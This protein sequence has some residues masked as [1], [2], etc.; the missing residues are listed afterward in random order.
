MAKVEGGK[1]LAVD[2]LH[3]FEIQPILSIHVGGLNLSFTNS[4]LWMAIA[5][6]AAVLLLTLATRN[7]ALVP[8]R[9]QNIAE[10][11]YEM[12]ANML[13]DNVGPEGRRYFP[14]IFT[15]FIFI[16][17]GNL[18]GMLPGSFTFTSH[19][20]VTFAM[21]AVIFIAVTVIGIALHGAHFLR[22][23]FPEGAPLWTAVILVPV[24]LV[25]YLS[26]PVSLSVRLFAN[27]MVGHTLLKVM[28]G[29]VVMLGFAGILPLALLVGITALE[30]LVAVLQAYVFTILTCIYLHDAIHLH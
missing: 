27:M 10:M 25:S 15:L 2:P 20:V 26:R 7:R 5:A 12:I 13:R 1:G 17:F 24:E 8:G 9:M 19:L 14:F 3:Q 16:L 22:L 29:F 11:L 28:G 18:L 23:F 30:F 4:A 21:A 6:V